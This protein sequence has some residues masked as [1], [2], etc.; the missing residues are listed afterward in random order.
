MVEGGF[1]NGMHASKDSNAA[2]VAINMAKGM[3]ADDEKPSSEINK[4]VFRS[5]ASISLPTCIFY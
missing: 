2:S 5:V 1:V 3:D 4:L